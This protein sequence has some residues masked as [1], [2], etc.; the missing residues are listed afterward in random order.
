MPPEE[1][2]RSDCTEEAGILL[3][4]RR[5]A[6]GYRVYGPDTLD[7]LAF[8]HQAQRLGPSPIGR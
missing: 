7:L 3:A 4:P 1:Q 2:A 6:A 8:I 5:T